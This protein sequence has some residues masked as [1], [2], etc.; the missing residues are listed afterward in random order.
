MNE[1][2]KKDLVFC[3]ECK[4]YID[5][6]YGEH[7]ISSDRCTN[8]K[9][10]EEKVSYLDIYYNY[11]EPSELNK[12]NNCPFYEKKKEVKINFSII[13]NISYFIIIILFFLLFIYLYL[14][15]KM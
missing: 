1:I 13:K 11:L 9:S 2:L 12:N 3:N 15:L 7:G 10:K 4:Y 5:R 8:S 14:F 6:H